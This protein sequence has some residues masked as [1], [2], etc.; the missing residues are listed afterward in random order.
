MYRKTPLKD[1]ESFVWG[2]H[3]VSDGNLVSMVVYSLDLEGGIEVDPCDNENRYQDGGFVVD[4][5][6]LEDNET[7]YHEGELEVDT[8]NLEDNETLYREGD[9]EVD[10]C[11]LEDNET[12][13]HEGDLEVDTCNLED[14][15]TLYHGGDL[16]VD[17]CNLEDNKTLYHEG[18]LEVDTCNLEDNETLYR[19][20][21][22]EVDP[23]DLRGNENAE[24]GMTH[25]DS[26]DD[27]EECD[28]RNDRGKCDPGEG[29]DPRHA[30]ERGGH[31]VATTAVFRHPAPPTVGEKFPDLLLLSNVPGLLWL[32]AHPVFLVVHLTFDP[33]RLYLCQSFHTVRCQRDWELVTVSSGCSPVYAACRQG[34]Y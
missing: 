2:Y 24:G 17:P 27:H 5:C 18:D 22:L 4:P 11:N 26:R 28:S 15:E 14:N 31:H 34:C 1:E 33:T 10:P 21:E 9:L 29:C 32:L 16:E 19:E 8:C 12:L 23:C 6:N 3:F 30:G 13:Y 25:C 7:L 20:G